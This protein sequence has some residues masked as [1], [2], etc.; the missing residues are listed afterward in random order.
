MVQKKTRLLSVS[1]ILLFVSIALLA[2]AILYIYAPSKALTNNYEQTS[3]NIIQ[4]SKATPLPS[5][6]GRHIKNPS[7]S[8]SG[9]NGYKPST[10]SPTDTSK[11]T[12]SQI[13]KNSDKSAIGGS[14]G[15]DGGEEQ[16]DDDKNRGNKKL[17][18]ILGEEQ[19]SEQ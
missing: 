8:G 11:S 12:S 13:S 1:N 3:K 6:H 10:T 5:K 7:G 17:T 9:S 19:Q 18:S 2:G 15:D 16:S 14:D 4:Q